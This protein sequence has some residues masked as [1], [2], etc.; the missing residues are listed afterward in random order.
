MRLTINEVGNDVQ[1]AKTL[2]ELVDNLAEG[3]KDELVSQLL[4]H[5]DFIDIISEG[6]LLRDLLSSSISNSAAARII[7]HVLADQELFQ[8]L[9]PTSYDLRE[10]LLCLDDDAAHVLFQYVLDHQNEFDS[11]FKNRVNVQNFLEFLDE[12]FTTDSEYKKSFI[13]KVIS[14][15]RQRFS[16]LVGT[17]KELIQFARQNFWVCNRLIEKGIEHCDSIS[18]LLELA[19]TIKED[20]FLQEA[21]KNELL[22]LVLE[23][24]W[25]RLL[26]KDEMIS[27]IK[28]YG[29]CSAIFSQEELYKL[30]KDFV[31][32]DSD[33][34]KLR[35]NNLSE[36]I[37][38]LQILS[39][40]CAAQLFSR[41]LKDHE[42]FKQIIIDNK[43]LSDLL[44]I[45][46]MHN[47]RNRGNE[48]EWAKDYWR[49]SDSL[50]TYDGYCFELK[51][52]I[53][54]GSEEYPLIKDSVQ[55]LIRH[56]ITVEFHGFMWDITH[57]NQAQ[58]STRVE[59]ANINSFMCERLF[60][61][62]KIR[63]QL[64]QVFALI[65]VPVA[66]NLVYQISQNQN[67]VSFLGDTPSLSFPYNLIYFLKRAIDKRDIV[68]LDKIQNELLEQ[69]KN[70][71]LKPLF[72]DFILQVAVSEN[73]KIPENSAF[74]ERLERLIHAVQQNRVP[75]LKHLVTRFFQ[76]ATEIHIEGESRSDIVKQME[77]IKKLTSNTVKNSIFTSF[78]TT[79]PNNNNSNLNISQSE[80]NKRVVNRLLEQAKTNPE[81]IATIFRNTKFAVQFDAQELTQLALSNE[82]I[83]K[84]ILNQLELIKRLGL[85]DIMALINT[86][87]G[88]LEKEPGIAVIIVQHPAINLQH[89]E[90]LMIAHPNIVVALVRAVA[91]NPNKFLEFVKTNGF[92]TTLVAL[93]KYND[94]AASVILGCEFNK[95]LTADNLTE[96][97]TSRPNVISD[98]LDNELLMNKLYESEATE[99]L[100]VC[101]SM[102]TASCKP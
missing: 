102:Q 39:E 14:L 54:R 50:C 71:S 12:D 92:G 40:E 88:I 95:W 70:R 19:K 81:A 42:L 23:K 94:K 60:K 86:Y 61:S 8:S 48:L 62:D 38:I 66:L 13:E 46:S 28:F 21:R 57:K 89:L 7:E 73:Q 30:A 64:P 34:L 10:T 44:F 75:S 2:M 37:E 18:E 69:L 100:A 5:S 43:K 17:K 67:L 90:K 96:I 26:K 32:S 101:L 74:K 87:P 49:S 63:A 4:S 1:D 84:T 56:T 51:P 82:K 25:E 9:I 41:V 91:G 58:L 65:P 52:G 45:V 53:Y 33:F 22:P 76:K 78:L 20:K 59:Q 99:L 29:E 97:Y 93:A 36:L 72:I 6:E 16:E 77:I 83:A 24:L 79:D 35:I 80:L 31:A 15:S 68:A 11:F 85:N 3:E 98:I 27:F 55:K 47:G